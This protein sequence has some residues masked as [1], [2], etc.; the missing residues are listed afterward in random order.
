[1][2]SEGRLSDFRVELCRSYIDGRDGGAESISD[3]QH[4][5]Y[6]GPGTG[7]GLTEGHP[8]GKVESIEHGAVEEKSKTR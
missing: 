5:M 7:Q 3:R 8:E 4:S 1:M 6:K 2:L